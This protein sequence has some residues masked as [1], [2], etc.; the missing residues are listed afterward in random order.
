MTLRNYLIVMSVLTLVCWSIFILMIN[1]IDPTSTNW[2]GFSLFYF[3]L[4]LSLSGTIALVGFV[5]RFVALKRSLV[6]YA[7]ANAF[8]QSFLFALFIT[9][10]L[11]L[12]AADLFTWLNIGLLF[13]VFIVLELFI[14]SYKKTK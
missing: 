4:F 2:L 14:S 6:F 9:I 10:A 8:R 5:I 3:S 11:F 13:I 7:V 12:L 1:A